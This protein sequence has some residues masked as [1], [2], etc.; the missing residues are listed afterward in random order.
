MRANIAVP[1]LIVRGELSD[2]RSADRSILLDFFH[3]SCHWGRANETSA[4]LALIEVATAFP[5]SAIF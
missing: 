5:G 1:T 4:A 2:V 3:T